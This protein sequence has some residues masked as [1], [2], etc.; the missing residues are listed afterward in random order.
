MDKDKRRTNFRRLLSLLLCLMMLSAMPVSAL[1]DDA[2]ADTGIIDAQKLN[3]MTES[4]LSERGIDPKNFSL[5]FCYTATGDEWYYHGDEGRSRRIRIFTT[6]PCP[7]SKI[8]YSPT[9]T[10]IG[11][12]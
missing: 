2:A 8:L 1:A 7:R 12:T 11:R 9:R 10:M 3:E 5:G 6:R 4:F